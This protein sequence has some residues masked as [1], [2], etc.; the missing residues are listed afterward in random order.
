MSN[1]TILI[2]DDNAQMVRLLKENLLEPL[3]Y[4]VLTAPD[5]KQGLEIVLQDTPDLI[6]LDM[7]MPQ[8]TGIEM[9][10]ALRQTVCDAPVIFMT[11]EPSLHVAVE[12]FRLGVRN[13]LSKPFSLTEVE[14]AIDG[15]L[16]EKR[17]RAMHETMQHNLLKADTI[18]QTVVTLSHYINN[19]LM[20]LSINL[21]MIQGMLDEQSPEAQQYISECW[22]CLKRIKAV[23][24]VLGSITD[25]KHAA[26]YENISM[27][28]I[29]SA[30]EA[31]LAK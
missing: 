20:S 21:E 1:E 2:V 12:A 5:G 16:E 23:M 30:L 14:Q 18:Q 19:D 17:L 8:M 25:V 22:T 3:G 10:M 29:E 27:I 28:N 26:Y 9:L 7:N 31:A 15:A 4:R 13:Y 24:N 6:L 11:V